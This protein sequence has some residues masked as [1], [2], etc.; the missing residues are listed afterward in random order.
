MALEYTQNISIGGLT[1]EVNPQ[2]YLKKSEKMGS[3]DRTV[4]GSL[5]SQDVSNRKYVFNIG[6]LTQTQID[7]LQM[8]V[9]AEFNFTLIDF[10]PISERGEAS[11]TVYELLDTQV[12]NGETI[13]RYIPSYVV[14]VVN[15]TE[16]YEGNSVTYKIIAEEM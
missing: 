3:F 15:Y 10:V 1:L 5:L 14:A 9:A 2:K 8:Y 12:V 13:V 4:G 7:D 16:E 6:G 11:R